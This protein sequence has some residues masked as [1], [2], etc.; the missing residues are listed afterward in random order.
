MHHYSVPMEKSQLEE[1]LLNCY[2]ETLKG[3]F[4]VGKKYIKSKNYSKITPKG[5]KKASNILIEYN[6]S[7]AM[8]PYFYT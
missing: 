7:N 5:D 3:F 2:R 6:N 4:F 8:F 1:Y